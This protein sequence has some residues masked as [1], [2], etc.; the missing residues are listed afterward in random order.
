MRSSRRSSALQKTA[1]VIVM[2]SGI[3]RHRFAARGEISRDD[4]VNYAT[5]DQAEIVYPVPLYGSWNAIGCCGAAATKN[6][7]DLAFLKALVAKVDP[8][9]A[10]QIDVV[11]YSNGARLA[12]R[13]ACDNP[14]LFDGYAM[15]KGEPTPAARCA[16]RS[17]PADRIGERPRGALQ[18]RRPGQRRAAAGDD[19]GRPAAR[20]GKVP[21]EAPA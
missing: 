21:G 10:R 18:A 5:S 9:H 11:G 2:L 13:V 15:V 19:P 17:T 7:N 1:P 12:Y 14:G 8:G 16:S 6:V 3:G 20:G 4:L